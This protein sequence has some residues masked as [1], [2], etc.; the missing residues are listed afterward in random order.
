[1]ARGPGKEGAAA[2]QKLKVGVISCVVIASDSGLN[3]YEELGR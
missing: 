3:M 1:M 2:L